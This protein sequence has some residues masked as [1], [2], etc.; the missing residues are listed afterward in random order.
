MKLYIAHGHFKTYMFLYFFTVVSLVLT[1][2]FSIAA[3]YSI[4]WFNIMLASMIVN[5][6][7]FVLIVMITWSVY[8]KSPK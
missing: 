6:L 3:F 8:N 5:I 1:H 4:T 2:L 7:Q